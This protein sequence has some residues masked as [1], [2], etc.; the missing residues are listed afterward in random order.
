MAQISKDQLIAAH[1]RRALDL[2]SDADPDAQMGHLAYQ[3]YA[4]AA[5]GRDHL[6]RIAPAE[7]Q[8]LPQTQRDAWAYAA[9]LVTVAVEARAAGV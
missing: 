8:D 2:V 4:E 1:L 9:M 5:G 3:A 7:W 6:D